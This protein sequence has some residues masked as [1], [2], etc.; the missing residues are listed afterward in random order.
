MMI[1]CILTYAILLS[2]MSALAQP[3][4]RNCK[5][6]DNTV[7]QNGG[8][9]Y[10]K[11]P[12][13]ITE[14]FVQNNNSNSIGG[15]IAVEAR[16]GVYIENCLVANNT[17][18][19]KAGGVWLAEKAG[20]LISATVVNNALSGPVGVSGI[21]VEAG[22]I[23]ANAIVFGNRSTM[24]AAF[25]TQLEG[26]GSLSYC[27]MQGNFISGTGNIQVG[28]EGDEAPVLDFVRPAEKIGY[29]SDN[30]S[31]MQADWTPAVG[32]PVID[33]G[34]NRVVTREIDLA[35]NT[36]IVNRI[37]DMGAFE[38]GDNASGFARNQND[39][40]HVVFDPAADRVYF[41]APLRMEVVCSVY[42]LT[43]RCLM[44]QC[45]LP[46]ENSFLSTGSLAGGI[47]MAVMQVNG[48]NTCVKFVK[49]R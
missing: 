10:A 25:A 13:V 22:S 35:R 27:A 17:A 2:G 43:G 33:M 32:A 34:D 42:D 21:A 16:A 29:A 14:V 5:V 49:N 26:H 39:D 36:R 38:Q 15:G 23:L 12:C 6:Y 19:N 45:F 28:A 11:T 40:I 47:Y 48:K 37:V 18:R 1:R 41:D 3:V 44:E 31:W 30:D 4:I 7:S 20:T 8:G 24:G 46:G 9:I